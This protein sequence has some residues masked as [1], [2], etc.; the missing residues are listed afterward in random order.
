MDGIRKLDIQ[1]IRVSL[2]KIFVLSAE[3]VSSDVQFQ[4]D[5][6]K[7]DGMATSGI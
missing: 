4:K 6:G 3:E 1:T 5:V 2:Q 7:K